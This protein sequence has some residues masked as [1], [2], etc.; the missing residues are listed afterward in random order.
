[1]SGMKN[2]NRVINDYFERDP[3]KGEIGLEVE[4]EGKNLPKALSS[5]W[6][7]HADGSLRG[8]NAEYVLTE[9]IKRENV[10]PYLKYLASKL[11]DSTVFDSVRTSVHVH[12]NMQNRTILQI[13]CILLVYF[14]LEDIIV[15][16]A[17]EDRVGNLF[18]LRL[19]DADYLLAVLEKAARQ[20][21]YTAFFDEG[22]IRYAAVNVCALWKFN[23][24]EFRALKGTTDPKTI[25]DWVSL[26]LELI[27]NTLENYRVPQDIIRDFSAIGPSRFIQKIFP[28]YHQRLLEVHPQIDRVLWDG[29]RLVQG[30]AF[31]TDWEYSDYKLV[32]RTFPSKKK[33][34]PRVNLAPRVPPGHAVATW[35]DAFIGNVMAPEPQ[36]PRVDRA[37]NVIEDIQRQ[38]RQMRDRVREQETRRQVELRQ[39]QF[40]EENQRINNEIRDNGLVLR[41]DIVWQPFAEEP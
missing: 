9:P 22:R 13:Y 25:H 8:E 24:L 27:D 33:G 21:S 29:L 12:V 40:I 11:K 2:Y 31:A 17:G 14:I 26:L 41:N 30:I 15:S 7:V 35:R 20:D 36:A 10:L 16:L 38:Q 18:C 32:E 28:T 39:Q 23:S 19:K 1:M 4:V 34:M 37:I 6:A 5:Y 3:V